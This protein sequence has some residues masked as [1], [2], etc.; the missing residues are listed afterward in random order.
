MFESLTISSIFSGDKSFE[1]KGYHL[2][3]F[4]HFSNAPFQ[5]QKRL[6]SPLPSFN[7]QTYYQYQRVVSHH[8]H[9]KLISWIYS[10]PQ[11][12]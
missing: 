9:E 11:L 6:P 12:N 1:I 7:Q 4:L 8:F 3:L 10:L 2:S 5:F